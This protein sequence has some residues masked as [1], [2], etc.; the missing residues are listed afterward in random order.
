[1]QSF[2]SRIWTRVAVFISYD[3]NHYTTGT[4]LQYLDDKSLSL[5]IR[6]ARDNG[7]K[8]KS[9]FPL[10]RANIFEKTGIRVYY[11]LYNNIS[12]TQKEAGEV[13]SDR[14]LI[15]M[16][17]KGLSPN[18]K[19]FTA[20]ITQKKKTLN[21]FWIQSIFKL[22]RNREYVFHPTPDESND[23]LQMKT[24]FKKINPRNWGKYPFS[25]WL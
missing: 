23:I 25:L 8:A 6:D 20:V 21:L 7:R 15:A 22:W 2:S 5:V 18:F 11:T 9:Y 24:T 10:Y 16:V 14:L 3:G 19:P 4:S 13:I 12:N 17:L 1:M